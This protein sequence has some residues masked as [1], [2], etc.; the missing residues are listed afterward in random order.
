M[1][2]TTMPVLQT[3]NPPHHSETQAVLQRACACGRHTGNGGECAECRKK[4]LGLQRRAV[5][6]GPDVA[7]PIV[8][9]VLRSPGRPLDDETRSLMES[10]FGHDFS[11]V[12]VHTNS[13]AAESARAV[14]A[15]AYTAGEHVAF[16]DGQYAPGTSA[17]RWL[18]AHELTHVVQQGVSGAPAVARAGLGVGA[19]DD[20]AEREA[21]RVAGQIASGAAVGPLS[22]AAPVVQRL[23]DL[24]KRP[25]G[26]ACPV[27]GS[28]P[29]PPIQSH[30]F[31]QSD[32]VLSPA[33]RLD[34][35]NF[36]TAWRAAGTSPLVRVDGYAST[37]G[38]DDYNWVLSCDRAQAVSQEL[39]NPTSGA[40]GIP[41]ANVEIF[42]HGE[43]FDFSPTLPPNRRATI[44][45]TAPLPVCTHPGQM[46]FLN[47]QPV[48]LRSSIYD[49]L[50]TGLTWR[51]R[52]NRAVT[53]WAKVGVT[54]RELS[55]V[56]IVTPLKTTGASQAEVLR[57]F[58]LR[59]GAGIEVFMVDNDMTSAGGGSTGIGAD[60][61]IVLSDRGTSDTLLA[62]EIGH[63]LGL[64]HPG[65]GTAAEGEAS[66]IMEIS[67]SN[68]TP[69][70]T[71]NTQHNHDRITCPA[72]RGSTCITPDP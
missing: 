28:S 45:T 30:L 64:D 7:P 63:V 9:E 55:P 51:A 54:L 57:V 21:V 16:G 56:T 19:T 41:P 1:I 48:F 65:A 33:Q 11:G 26:L 42:A 14:D 46:R 71:R 3:K 70:P 50:A 49:M 38:P 68:S 20:A 69:N 59:S 22:R 6:D 67:G 27:A 5:G 66:T 31:A 12:R 53:I 62:H 58:A 37:E 4:R 61:K 13:P 29:T 34:I 2:Q 35:E 25:S 10:R 24:S 32:D 8:H 72:S 52:F 60:R 36:V 18:L 15:L 43:T 23:G 44:T 47:V 39:M 17:G 40:P